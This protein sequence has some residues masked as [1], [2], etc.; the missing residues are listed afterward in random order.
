MTAQTENHAAITVQMHTPQD[1]H[2]VKRSRAQNQNCQHGDQTTE[3]W[4][5]FMAES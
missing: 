3:Q 5:T 4:Y 2:K 1:A